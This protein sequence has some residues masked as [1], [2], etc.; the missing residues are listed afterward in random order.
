MG[1]ATGT[2]AGAAPSPDV[3]VQTGP[4]PHG[5]LRSLAELDEVKDGDDREDREEVTVGRQE[6]GSRL[7]QTGIYCS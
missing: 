2:A 1:V 7:N 6:R 5:E 4:G 3:T